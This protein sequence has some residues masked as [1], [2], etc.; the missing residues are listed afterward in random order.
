[1]IS[2]S[3]CFHYTQPLVCWSLPHTFITAVFLLFAVAI[4]I[5]FDREQYTSDEDLES[6]TVTLTKSNVTSEQTFVFELLPLSSSS[7]GD[8]NLSEASTVKFLSNQRTLDIAIPVKN[9]DETEGIEM[10][11][12]S[13]T[14]ATDGPQF[15]KSDTL[16]TVVVIND[17]EVFG[18]PRTI[19]ITK[20]NY[21]INL[22]CRM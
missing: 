6:V 3:C 4:N 12:V 20:P 21:T 14:T 18:E 9:D 22:S 19:L 13:L 8:L 7:S 2:G 16:Q 17:D 11:Q 1:M 15:G 5:V 10:H